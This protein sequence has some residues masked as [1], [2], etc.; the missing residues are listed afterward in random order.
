MIIAT[1][2]KK[3]DFSSVIDKSVTG[4]DVKYIIVEH[5][6]KQIDKL[7]SLAYELEKK[8]LMSYIEVKFNSDFSKRAKRLDIVTTDNIHNITIYKFTSKEKF[9]SDGFD[10]NDTIDEIQSKY[11]HIIKSLKGYL[12][13]RGAT[14]DIDSMKEAL[15]N[16]NLNISLLNR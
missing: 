2:H 8:G 15:N 5:P 4:Q 16:L 9:E 11:G 7:T 12:V 10:L 3:Y 14:Q 6:S 1:I 13:T